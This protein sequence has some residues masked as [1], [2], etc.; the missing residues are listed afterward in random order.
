[1]SEEKTPLG[2]FFYGAREYWISPDF[3]NK[4]SILFMP[5]THNAI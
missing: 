4:A 1:M 5:R 2:A 3:L